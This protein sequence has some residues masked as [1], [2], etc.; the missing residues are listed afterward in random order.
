MKRTEV[1]TVQWKTVPQIY[2]T[3]CKEMFPYI[4]AAMI[5]VHFIWMTT[6]RSIE[7]E[8][9]PVQLFWIRRL[10]LRSYTSS[11]SN[12]AERAADTQA[13]PPGAPGTCQVGQLVRWQVGRHVK[14]GIRE[15]NRG[16][17]LISQG[18]FEQPV[19]RRIYVM[20][21][22]FWTHPQLCILPSL[23]ASCNLRYNHDGWR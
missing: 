1:I 4:D 2:N 17:G 15:W 9:V 7:K 8:E 22:W 23:I 12:K 19:R 6:S 16:G 3:T 13:L 21:L 11:A 5:C 14:C 20:S 18:R 10:I